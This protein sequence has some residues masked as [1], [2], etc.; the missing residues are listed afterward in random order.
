MA[1]KT[2][3]IDDELLARKRIMELLTDRNEFDVI[4]EC[5][6]GEDAI[7]K[8]NELSPDVIFLDIELKGMTGFD[9]LRNIHSQKMPI[10]VFA[11]AYDYYAV[12]AF[13]NYAL[14]FLLKPFKNKRFHE[15]LERILE[16]MQH[17]DYEERMKG[18]LDSL[19]GNLKKGHGSNTKKLPIKQD[20]KTIF[21]NTDQVKYVCASSY[22]A[23][24]YIGEKK[25]VVRDSLKNLLHQLT[26]HQFIRIH[27]STIINVDHILE[28]VHSDYNEIDI[29]MNDL[30]LFRISKSYRKDTLTKLGIL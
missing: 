29:R 9:V 12:D 21:L 28:L 26:D 19:D 16:R 20:N 15:T 6:N 8:I 23:E 4:A 11:T 24:I 7:G 5:H 27:R 25:Y 13:N 2:I 14:D 17:L 22:Y 18:F 30:K 1:H 3:I 10:V